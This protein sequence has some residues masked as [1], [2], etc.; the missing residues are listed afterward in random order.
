MSLYDSTPTL[1]ELWRLSEPGLED[2][3]LSL[4]PGDYRLTVQGWP[5]NTLNRER[6][7]PPER[8]D[9]VGDILLPLTVNP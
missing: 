7:G 5:E 2:D 9:V 4:P 8:H 1:I 6:R 3:T